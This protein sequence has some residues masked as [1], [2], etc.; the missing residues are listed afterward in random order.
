MTLKDKI[1]VMSDNFKDEFMTV[2]LMKN[3]A[4]RAYLFSMFMIH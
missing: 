4:F 3:I 1:D 2:K